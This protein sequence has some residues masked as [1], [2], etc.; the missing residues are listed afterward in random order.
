VVGWRDVGVGIWDG[1]VA[2]KLCGGVGFLD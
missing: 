1:V 2:W